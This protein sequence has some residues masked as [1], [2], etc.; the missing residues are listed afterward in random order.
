ME[1]WSKIKYKV[2]L[3]IGIPRSI[4]WQNL[5]S[6]EMLTF[7]RISSKRIAENVKRLRIPTSQNDPG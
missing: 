5:G 2:G 6:R 3:L 1:V 4:F 7:M